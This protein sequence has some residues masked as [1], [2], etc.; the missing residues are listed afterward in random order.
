MVLTVVIIVVVS[1]AGGS[2]ATYDEPTTDLCETI[3]S[4]VADLGA[5]DLIVS[6]GENPKNTYPGASVSCV[7]QIDESSDDYSNVT[8]IYVSVEG[9]EDGAS[10][11]TSYSFR[12][13]D[14]VDKCELSDFEG[15]WEQGAITNCQQSADGAVVQEGN[16]FIE[17]NIDH[18][19]AVDYPQGTLKSMTEKILDDL[20]T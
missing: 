19:G 11:S 20:R 9:H 1:G 6:D 3:R 7:V 4:E 18:G 8:N 12:M 16:L 17:F 15:A 13:D 5:T 14:V 2:S 10:A